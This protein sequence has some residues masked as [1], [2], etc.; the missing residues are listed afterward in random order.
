M[1]RK[2]KWC[3]LLA[4]GVAIGCLTRGTPGRQPRA[5][6]FSFLASHSTLCDAVRPLFRLVGR[7]KEFD[8]LLE[9]MFQEAVLE[10][11]RMLKLEIAMLCCASPAI[12]TYV[13]FRLPSLKFGTD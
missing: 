4:A 12:L 6:F 5:M 10:E 1:A 7:E 8:V 2:R 9:V 13:G 3:I 11:L